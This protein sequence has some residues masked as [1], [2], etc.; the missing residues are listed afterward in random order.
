VLRSKVEA[1]APDEHD[2]DRNARQRRGQN[3][4]TVP[5]TL[6]SVGNDLMAAAMAMQGADNAPTA[7]QMAA[8]ARARAKYRAVIA[9][10]NRIEESARASAGAN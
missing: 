10:W 4:P 6:E 8:C 7:N 1:L 2:G 5:P 3:Q 9:Q